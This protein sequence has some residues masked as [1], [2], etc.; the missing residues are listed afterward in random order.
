M[1]SV[2]FVLTSILIVYIRKQL[3]S[4]K[5]VEKVKRRNIEKKQALI[6][7]DVQV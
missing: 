5:E 4:K 2:V 7:V 6:V 3:S 1:S